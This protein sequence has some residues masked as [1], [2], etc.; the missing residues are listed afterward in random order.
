MILT[1]VTLTTDASRVPKWTC[2]N[3]K[4]GGKFAFFV[5]TSSISKRIMVLGPMDPSYT[6]SE[7]SE[8]LPNVFISKL[9]LPYADLLIAGDDLRPFAEMYDPKAPHKNVVV[10]LMDRAAYTY[11]DSATGELAKNSTPKDSCIVNTFRTKD[12]IGC[13]AVI[14]AD[15]KRGKNNPSRVGMYIDYAVNGAPRASMFHEIGIKGNPDGISLTVEAVDDDLSKKLLSIYKGPKRSFRIRTI[16][17]LTN[18]V[19]YPAGESGVEDLFRN[20][21][22][23]YLDNPFENSFYT[24]SVDE[25]GY[26]IEDEF[27]KNTLL[28]KFEKSRTNRNRSVV[29]YNCKPSSSF[30]TVNLSYIFVAKKIGAQDISYLS[31][32]CP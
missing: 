26:V 10:F 30:F 29:F 18:Y 23:D 25:N 7:I 12:W 32:V 2:Q 13:I 20:A 21:P 31:L 27:V 28:K 1:F 15:F 4:N 3:D 6:V 22:A 9:E 11:L 14:G 17:R 5:K 24:V 19:V 8:V 16:Q